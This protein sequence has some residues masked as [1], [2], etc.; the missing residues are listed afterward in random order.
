MRSSAVPA[1]LLLAALGAPGATAGQVI[2]LQPVLAFDAEPF[3]RVRGL[4]ERADGTLIVVDQVDN[5]V[6]RVDPARGER[7]Q[8]G[9]IGAG[10]GEFDGPTGIGP[11]S[12]DSVRV[13]DLGNGRL[14]VLGPN[15]ETVRTLPM[16]GEQYSIPRASDVA[17]R[18][19]FDLASRVRSARREDRTVEPV[20]AIVRW[21]GA[22]GRADTVGRIRFPGEDQPGPFPPWDAW[23]VGADGRVAIVRN[24]DAYRLD[25]VLPDGRQV[26]GPVVEE[27]RIRLTERDRATW[28]KRYPQGGSR[29]RMAGQPAPPAEPP[30]F[31]DRF[32]YTAT[33]GA[34]VDHAGRAWVER[35]QPLAESRPL[36][37]VFDGSGR[38]VARVRL[39]AGRRVVGFGP[40]GLWAVRVDEVDLQWLERYD[41]T[42]IPGGGDG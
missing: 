26:R 38:R 40:G 39:P 24:Q 19:Y 3:S 6:Y 41:V 23:G 35:S 1:A 36:L 13:T 37:D 32:P 4:V 15:L 8:I 2:E 9:R 18:L 34:H 22:A 28:M 16:F 11:W 29:V 30:V 17:G 25:W 14:A 20:A 42:G 5:A 31:P 21:D 10:P 33:Q 27:D 7:A 12:G